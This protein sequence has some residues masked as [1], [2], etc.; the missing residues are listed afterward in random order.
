MNLIAS[1]I[2]RSRTAHT[3][4]PSIAEAVPANG[5][6][7]SSSTIETEMRL[8]P[9]HSGVTM[10]HY[11]PL[12]TVGKFPKV[13]PIAISVLRLYCGYPD[14]TRLGMLRRGGRVLGLRATGY[15]IRMCF[16]SISFWSSKVEGCC[17]AL[18]RPRVEQFLFGV[19]FAQIFPSNMLA[20]L[21]TFR[22][23]PKAPFV[24]RNLPN[25]LK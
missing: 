25:F 6:D 3:I 9:R 14:V 7:H 11:A 12:C 2:E 4:D 5:G 15:V 23:E 24:L 22:N 21:Q 19:V 16:S 18:V 20:Y 8:L 10:H 17:V 1:K 13:T